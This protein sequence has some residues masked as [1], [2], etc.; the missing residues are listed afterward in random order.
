MQ[1]TAIFVEWEMGKRT[2]TGGIMGTETGSRPEPGAGGQRGKGV[3]G[4]GGREK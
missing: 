4:L 1:G 3:E 2:Q